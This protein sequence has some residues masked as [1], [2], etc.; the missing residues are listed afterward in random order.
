MSQGPGFWNGI[1]TLPSRITRVPVPQMLLIALLNESTNKISKSSQCL[2]SFILLGAKM[3]IAKAWN[4]PRCWLH[5]KE[6]D[7]I[8]YG[9]WKKSLA[10]LMIRLNR[11]RRYRVLGLNIWKYSLMP[12]RLFWISEVNVSIQIFLTF[13]SLFLFPHFT[14]SLLLGIPFHFLIWL[15]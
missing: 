1:F 15:S 14:G 13:S 6:E 5:G 3:T 4:N 2:I 12:N 7:I 9:P 11:L 10:F 8:D